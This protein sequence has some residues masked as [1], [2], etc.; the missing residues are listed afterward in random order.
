MKKLLFIGLGLSLGL[1]SCNREDSGTDANLSQADRVVSYEASDLVGGL[2]EMNE[3]FAIAGKASSLSYSYKAYAEPPQVNGIRTNATSVFDIRDVVFV[4]WHTLNSPYGGAI[5]AYK[6][7]TSTGKYVFTDRID[8]V[9]TDFHE[10]TGSINTGNG[11]YEIFAAGQRDPDASGYLLS[12][13]NGAVVTSIH[14]DYINDAF[15]ASTIKELPLP[16][17]GANGIIA[18]AGSY[19]V[20]TGN[21]NGNSGVNAAPGGIYKTDYALTNVA[22]AFSLNDGIAVT[23]DP[24]G[25]SATGA[26]IAYADRKTNTEFDIYTGDFID[27]SPDGDLGTVGGMPTTVINAV[28]KSTRLTGN[29]LSS[30][31]N[32]T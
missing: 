30:A 20:V 4:T 13:H 10:A 18:A 27:D 12:S 9:D 7:N 29:E 11:T 21:G 5:T 1:T 28:S 14:Y 3:S 17:Y 23:R 25:A 26:S 19:Y 22:A 16:S 24:S 8:F 31:L 2:V 6:L 15:D 32:T